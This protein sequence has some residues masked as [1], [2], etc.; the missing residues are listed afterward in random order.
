M[1]R[2]K[3]RPTHNINTQNSQT[4]SQEQPRHTQHPSEKAQIPTPMHTLARSSTTWCGSRTRICVITAASKVLAAHADNRSVTVCA[5]GYV[6]VLVL[7]VWRQR[8]DE[9]DDPGYVRRETE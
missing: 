6:G 5:L 2:L 3:T 4:P 8:G 9:G 1:T 7:A